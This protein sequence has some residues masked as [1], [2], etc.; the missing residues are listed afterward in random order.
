MGTGQTLLTIMAMLM[1][2]RMALSINQSNAQSGSAVEMAAYRIT[3]TS[4]ATSMIE[5]AQG[6]AFD[7][8]SDTVGISNVSNFTPANL[9]GPDAGEVYPAYNDCD[10]FNGL[11]KVDSLQ[12]SAVFVTDV[13]VEYVT[14]TGSTI[15]AATTQTYNKRIT[16]MVSS[17]FLPDT[18]KFY[19]IFSYWFF[20]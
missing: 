5:E 4:L 7:Q 1:L 15:T 17:K 2:S 14:I 6:L 11:H 18:V 20:R 8:K 9:L 10:D 19:N 3:A 12:G 13:K 16:V